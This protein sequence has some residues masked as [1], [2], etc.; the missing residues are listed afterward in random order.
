MSEYSRFSMKHGEEYAIR[1][2]DGIR[3]E[4]MFPNLNV[5]QE[6]C[7]MAIWLEGNP[8]RRKTQRGIKR[9]I[10]NWLIKSTREQRVPSRVAMEAQIGT[11]E[12]ITE[13]LD[14]CYCYKKQD[15]TFV[16]CPSCESR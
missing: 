13:K 9:F 1:F 2:E 7:S 5:A 8:A 12:P 3:Y 16:V 11:P 10:A 4:R 15:G 6:F 14:E